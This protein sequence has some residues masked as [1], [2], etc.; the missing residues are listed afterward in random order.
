MSVPAEFVVVVQGNRQAVQESP[1]S[2]I[3]SDDVSKSEDADRLVFSQADI[4][5]FLPAAESAQVFS[6]PGVLL[7][8]YIATLVFQDKTPV[9]KHQHLVWITEF[10]VRE[11]FQLYQLDAV[12]D[13]AEVRQFFALIERRDRYR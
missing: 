13:A 1:V 7:H 8:F 2:G 5:H 12:D 10:V 9:L 11:A 4:L 3:V 6:V